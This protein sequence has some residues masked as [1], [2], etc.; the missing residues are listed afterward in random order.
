MIQLLN[1]DNLCA[2]QQHP[3][4]H[5]DQQKGQTSNPSQFISLA[6]W[7]RADY[8]CQSTADSTLWRLR[9][10]SSSVG[11]NGQC[12]YWSL[13]TCH[14]NVNQQLMSSW[15]APKNYFCL[16]RW[17]CSPTSWRYSIYTWIY[18]WV[19][20]IYGSKFLKTHASAQFVIITLAIVCNRK[21]KMTSGH[22]SLINFAWPCP[23]HSNYH[24]DQRWM[25]PPQYDVRSVI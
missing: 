22:T 2:F 5:T 14:Y 25:Q 19:L 21:T 9:R 11:Q 16:A 6:Q 8:H 7:Q 13:P 23:E 3:S 17:G 12:A 15:K 1:K 10:Y 4:L 24:N 18:T 20:Q